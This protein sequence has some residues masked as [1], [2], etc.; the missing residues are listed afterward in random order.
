MFEGLGLS[1]APHR[2]RKKRE[3]TRAVELLETLVGGEGEVHRRAKAPITLLPNV[4]T[5]LPSSQFTV[6]G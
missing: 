5:S 3:L 4:F 1:T 6:K 2:L